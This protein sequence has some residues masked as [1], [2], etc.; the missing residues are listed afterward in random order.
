MTMTRL[1]SE[2]GVNTDPAIS[3]DGKFLVY[4]S[5]RSGENNLDLWLKQAG[6]KFRAD[7]PDP[8]ARG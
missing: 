6:S 5:D 2:A 3:P 7:S 4:A 8:F 1:V